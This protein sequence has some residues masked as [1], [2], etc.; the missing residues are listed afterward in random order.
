M[1]WHLGSLRWTF[2]SGLYY[3]QDENLII[4]IDFTIYAFI[5]GTVVRRRY[6]RLG[7]LK[8]F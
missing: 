1:Y 6:L 5:L 4:F 2:A 8:T 7:S 3:S